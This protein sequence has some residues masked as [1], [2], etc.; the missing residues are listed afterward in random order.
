MAAKIAVDKLVPKPIHIAISMQGGG[1]LSN[2]N[3]NI[4]YRYNGGGFG[5]TEQDV[6]A[7]D[8]WGGY[9][10]PGDT[11]TD[12]NQ[13]TRQGIQVLPN[14]LPDIKKDT[15][16]VYDDIFPETKVMD[17]PYPVSEEVTEK[18][19]L[20]LTK[21]GWPSSQRFL[22][23]FNRHN[24]NLETQRIKDKLKDRDDWS[25][26]TKS[27]Q[28]RVKDYFYK[29]QGK[30]KETDIIPGEY[31]EETVDKGVP[32]EKFTGQPLNIPRSKLGQN[33]ILPFMLRKEPTDEKTAIGQ[34]MKGIFDFPTPLNKRAWKERG[35]STLLEKGRK[36]G[37]DPKIIEDV[38]DKEQKRVE[39]LA[40]E[41]YDDWDWR[42]VLNRKDRQ[43]LATGGQTMPR[44][45]SGI[46]D[47]ININ[48]QPHRLVWA[49][50]KEERVLKDMGGSGKKVLG[51]PA[52]FIDYYGGEDSTEP[53][54]DFSDYRDRG[55]ADILAGTET[56]GSETG[57]YRD[58]E[59]QSTVSRY[60]G[61]FS[62]PITG[63][64]GERDDPGKATGF[65]LGAMYGYHPYTSP[66]HKQVDIG[67]PWLADKN[68][69]AATQ[70]YNLVEN[71]P[72]K[73]FL[74]LT[75]DRMNMSEAYEGAYKLGFTKWREG[76]GMYETDAPKAYNEWFAKQN[77][78]DLVEGY[79]YGD[80]VGHSTRS[81]MN[82]VSEQLKNKFTA[83]RDLGSV[84]QED[85]EPYEMTRK[86]YQEAAEDIEDI[87]D[88]TPF[89]G[90]LPAWMP[91]WMKAGA[92]FFS[93][94]VIGTG[95]VGGVGVHIHEDGTI[96]AVSP[97]DSP[98]YDHAAQHEPG[99]EVARRYRSKPVEQASIS[100]TVEKEPSALERLLA[101]RPE[102]SS[103]AQLDE[104]MKARLIK[105]F[106]GGRD[107]FSEVV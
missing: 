28:E 82:R 85:E 95:K 53:V 32:F 45:L 61:T 73:G 76:I 58:P 49:N 30:Y 40:T 20:G 27:E 50:P 67:L 16:P 22:Q 93:R 59:L 98:G 87:E 3:E 33:T 24:Y 38:W 89:D 37:I 11:G 63:G 25:T 103:L 48:G 10:D 44:G 81:S 47:S 88:F 1:G 57:V 106:Y 43:N 66:R 68:V 34:I 4:V 104:K 91:A 39:G 70:S 55:G 2:L 54:D 13:P 80:P 79:K 86:D 41:M 6:E 9:T 74:G 21:G 69:P 72:K 7:M 60:G 105:D 19:F 29:K 46:N 62:T 35:L 12:D 31:N 42:Q 56:V 65:G 26:Y 5:F 94:T 17:D 107:I 75:G 97:E 52:Y 83:A 102:P 51:K 78:Q 101:S 23:D 71:L 14:V 92:G 64:F 18:E 8:K 77:P 96:T 99:G 36:E 90:I 84:G 15:Y 100:E